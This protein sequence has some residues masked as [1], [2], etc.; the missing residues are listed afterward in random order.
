M[1]LT[2]FMTPKNLNI[3]F[4]NKQLI[5]HTQCCRIRNDFVSDPDADPAQDSEFRICINSWYD[6]KFVD[7]F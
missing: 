4:F 6:P 1:K 2:K 7:L 5:I 3:P